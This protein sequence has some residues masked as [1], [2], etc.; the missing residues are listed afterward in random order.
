M[1]LSTLKKI[2]FLLFFTFPTFSFAFVN[3]P[4]SATIQCVKPSKS[5]C[6]TN[7]KSICYVTSHLEY[8]WLL[9][10]PSLG[11][12]VRIDVSQGS[13]SLLQPGNYTLNYALSYYGV[14]SGIEAPGAYCMYTVTDVLAIAGL[15]N[16]QYVKMGNNWKQ[17]D[18]GYV[19]KGASDCLY[20]VL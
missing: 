20:A 2:A 3:C 15:Y 9:A 1:V 18:K 7:M 17:Y 6:A 16:T 11:G 12:N 19:C 10:A 4:I 13:C 5:Q 14:I 8:S